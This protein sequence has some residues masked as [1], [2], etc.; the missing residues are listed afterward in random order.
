MNIHV[1]QHVPFEGP[2]AI[3]PWAASRG[4]S[5]GVTR[6]YG[7]DS[8]PSLGNVDWLIVLGGPMG[9]YDEARYSWLSREKQWIEAAVS[10]GKT[11][12]GICLGAQLLAAVLGAPVRKNREREI[13]WFPVELTEE[14]LRAGPFRGMPR[15]F[16]VFHWHGDTFEVPAGA[17]LAAR[18]AACAHQAFF[19]G[20][21]V[22]ALQFHLEST[23]ESVRLLLDHCAED[24]SGGDFVQT[25]EEMVSEEGRFTELNRRLEVVLDRIERTVMP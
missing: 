7:G 1:F 17:V 24:L 2:A 9:V 6:F 20:D 19:Y 21:R 5:L 15:I 22:T 8:P 12:L 4:H 11:I 23:V 18:S 25:P 16:P 10:A 14:A 3:G 13:G